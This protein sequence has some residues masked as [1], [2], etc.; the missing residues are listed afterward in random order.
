[1]KILGEVAN[2]WVCHHPACAR[3]GQPQAGLP[4]GRNQHERLK[5]GIVVTRRSPRDAVESSS[6]SRPSSTRGCGK[7]YRARDS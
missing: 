6:I 2:R 1:M 5:V 3:V 7:S 4:V